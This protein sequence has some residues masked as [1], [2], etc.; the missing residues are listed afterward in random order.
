MDRCREYFK[1]ESFALQAFRI[2]LNKLDVVR[3]S[4]KDSKTALV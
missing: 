4:C 1:I 3:I 2:D